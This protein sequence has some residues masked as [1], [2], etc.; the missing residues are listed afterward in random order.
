MEL[1]RL[2][3]VEQMLPHFELV[4][5]LTASLTFE[6][7]K[8]LLAAMIPHNYAMIAA[9]EGDRCLGLSG[10]WIGHKLYSGKYMEIDNFIVDE[11][12][13]EQGIGGALVDQLEEEARNEGCR[14][15]M[16]DAYVENFNAHRFYYRQGFHARGFHYLK[17]L[18]T[19]AR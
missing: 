18:G 8:A 6:E 13:R 16:L 14:V 3:T 4:R 5:Q 19:G 17:Q 11:S 2:T 12:A 7:Y 1:R 9:F 10:Y 15:L